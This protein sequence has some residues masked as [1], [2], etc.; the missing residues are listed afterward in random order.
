[1]TVYYGEHPLQM[2]Y[3]DEEL[4]V[5]IGD[6]IDGKNK[7]GSKYFSFKGLC[8][9][10]FRQ[11]QVENMLKTEEDATYNNPVL[12]YDDATRISRL[13]WL[14]IWNKEIFIDFYENKYA[15]NYHEDTYFGII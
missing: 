3:N 2:I 1:M 9:T 4:N 14:R 10:L 5:K 11:A 12:D 15:A 7:D 13:L 6:F 8:H